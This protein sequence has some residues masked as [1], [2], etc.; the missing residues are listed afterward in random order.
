MVGLT[1]LLRKII[2]IIILGFHSVPTY[3]C[4]S[5]PLIGMIA[6]IGVEWLLLSPWSPFHYFHETRWLVFD[7]ISIPNFYNINLNPILGWIMLAL[8]FSIFL[9]A[10]V[11]FLTKWKRGFVVT[12]LYSKIR[13]PQY[14]GII[15]ATLGFTFLSEKPMAWISWFNL[16][17]LYVLLA[18]YEEKKLQKK[19]GETIENYMQRVP[20]I[21]PFLSPNVS[22]KFPIPKSQWKKYGF[23][24]LTY[25]II[26]ILAWMVLSELSYYP[27]TY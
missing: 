23:L 12:G 19:Y 17:F 22:K 6:P 11:Q 10:F 2:A 8:G 9:V 14:L 27:N 4:I 15:L 26:M 13:H 7:M 1:N 16:V 20:F 24:F 21:L 3:A 5:N 25:F 18:R